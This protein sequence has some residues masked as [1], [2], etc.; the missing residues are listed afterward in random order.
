MKAIVFNSPYQLKIK[1]IEKPL[2]K[3]DE[4][5]VRVVYAGI[6]G[7]DVSIIIYK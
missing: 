5:L 3:A 7:T 2:I 4:V 1:G 6:W